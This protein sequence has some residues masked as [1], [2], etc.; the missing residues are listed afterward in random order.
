M[1]KL[2]A[3]KAESTNH[4]F[5]NTEE[6]EVTKAM[7]LAQAERYNRASDD[8]GHL[9]G[10]IIASIKNYVEDRE[11]G[12]YAEYHMAFCAHYIGDL[13]MPLHNV[14]FDDFNERH[15]I[16]NDGIVEPG[17]MKSISLI[18]RSIYT[19]IISDENDLAKEIARIA[20]VAHRLALR[21]KRENRDMTRDEAYI[22]I[23]HSASLLRAVMA[24]ARG[25]TAKRNPHVVN[26]S[27]ARP[28]LIAN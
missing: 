9:Y 11:A 14:P 15:H 26:Q 23:S 2:K 22:E 20:N 24:Y 7:V 16:T 13:S 21:I 19:I 18:Q 1:T 8:E 28:L 12:K 25:K 17:V 6:V 27:C 4:W 5:N 10:A 3:G